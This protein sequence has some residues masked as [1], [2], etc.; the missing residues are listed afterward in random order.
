MET[1][2]LSFEEQ[3]DAKVK[4][5][6][7]WRCGNPADAGAG[8][9]LVSPKGPGISQHFLPRDVLVRPSLP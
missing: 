7:P 1:Q 9:S 8:L 4:P 6:A 5:T 3:P 2:K